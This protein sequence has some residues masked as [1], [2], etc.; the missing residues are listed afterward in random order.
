MVPRPSSRFPRMLKHAHES[1]LRM[2]NHL[3]HSPRVKAGAS[4]GGIPVL[5]M[6]TPARA[7]AVVYG[8]RTRRERRRGRPATTT[9]TVQMAYTSGRGKAPAASCRTVAHACVNS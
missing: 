5:R 3:L 8:C 2:I 4:R 6:V 1:P 7:H 9:Y